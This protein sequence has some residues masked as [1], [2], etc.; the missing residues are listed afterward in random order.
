MITSVNFRNANGEWLRDWV[1]PT[2][3]YYKEGDI[4]S[5]Y[6]CSVV[7]RTNKYLYFYQPFT[8]LF[9]WEVVVGRG[10]DALLTW[11]KGRLIMLL[12]QPS[13]HALRSPESTDTTSTSPKTVIHR[14]VKL[15]CSN[16]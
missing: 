2:F 9:L 12:G 7:E 11:A 4:T 1:W 14:Y 13:L 8:F 6:D 10:P 5:V 3:T 16:H 15:K